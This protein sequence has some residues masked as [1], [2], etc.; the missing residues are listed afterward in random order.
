M[1][2]LLIYIIGII[3]LLFLGG[4][5][6]FGLIIMWMV[7]QGFKA[8]DSLSNEELVKL[9]EKEQLKDLKQIVYNKR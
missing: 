6:L 2:E 7:C 3:L 1:I 4:L 8:R 5:F 9:Q